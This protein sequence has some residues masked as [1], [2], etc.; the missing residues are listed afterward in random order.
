MEMWNMNGVDRYI[1]KELTDVTNIFFLLLVDACLLQRLHLDG[2]DFCKI[3]GWL[4]FSRKKSRR[5][6]LSILKF[7]NLPL[8]KR[9]RTIT[10]KMFNQ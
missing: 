10:A 4:W 7:G 8:L 3:E 1:K 2:A 9:Q 5:G 6:C